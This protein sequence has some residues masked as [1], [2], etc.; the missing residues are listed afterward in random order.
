MGISP[1]IQWLR[2][3][4]P[5]QIW[6]LVREVRSHKL[7]VMTK[8]KINKIRFLPYKTWFLVCLGEKKNLGWIASSPLHG[9]LKPHHSPRFYILSSGPGHNL[10][11]QACFIALEVH[12]ACSLLGRKAGV[13]FKISFIFWPWGTAYG[14]LVPPLGTKRPCNGSSSSNGSMGSEPLNHQ[15]SPC[16]AF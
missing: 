16:E 3:C 13:I 5:A 1:V 10:T 4:L 9:F 15:G 8:K 6:P 11:S 7:N 12:G 14:I 2:L